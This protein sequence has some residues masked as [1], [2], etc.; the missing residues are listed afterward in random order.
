M[1]LSTVVGDRLIDREK[2]QNTQ[3]LFECKVL[4]MMV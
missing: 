4:G 2:G 3:E 1:W